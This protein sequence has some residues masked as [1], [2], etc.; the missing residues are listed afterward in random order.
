MDI[1]DIAITKTDSI[2]Q[3]VNVNITSEKTFEMTFQ[4]TVNFF[5][6]LRPITLNES[7]GKSENFLRC[8]NFFY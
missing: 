1:L 3:L 7:E 4:Q 5:T 6:Q 8:L 2:V